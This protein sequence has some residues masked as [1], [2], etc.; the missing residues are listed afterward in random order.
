MCLSSLLDFSSQG[1]FPG[2]SRD[3]PAGQNNTDIVQS[4]N[5]K[6][7]ITETVKLSVDEEPMELALWDIRGIDY[8]PTWL[9]GAHVALV[10]FSV[11][12]GSTD[13]KGKH[14]GRVSN[15]FSVTIPTFPFSNKV[16][17]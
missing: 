12:I 3:L 7:G 5:D 1:I 11:N 4:K 10:C 17:R 2:F 8:D 15:N 9:H 16:S 13:S 6:C 14:L